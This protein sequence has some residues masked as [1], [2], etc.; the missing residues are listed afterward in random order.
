M[1]GDYFPPIAA[2]AKA[3]AATVEDSQYL[4]MPGVI[5]GSVRTENL[6]LSSGLTVF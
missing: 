6:P 3:V 4:L 2:A 5:S 1:F